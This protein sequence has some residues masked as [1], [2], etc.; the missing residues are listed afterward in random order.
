MQRYKKTNQPPKHME[1]LATQHTP[2]TL[3]TTTNKTEKINTT[4]ISQNTNNSR[5]QNIVILMDSNRKFIEFRKLLSN[6]TE[7]G[8]PIVVIPCGN[9]RKTETLPNSPKFTDPSKILIHV[10]RGE[11]Y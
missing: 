1:I 7:D 2:P 8:G 5:K 10:G 9:V 3:F 11:R 6:E 4:P